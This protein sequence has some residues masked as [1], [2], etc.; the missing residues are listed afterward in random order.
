MRLVPASSLLDR[1]RTLCD[2]GTA[3]DA[4][5]V[6]TRCVQIPAVIMPL[7]ACP[8]CAPSL[9]VRVVEEVA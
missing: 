1:P 3:G 2:L 4:C 8:T 7:N 5:E 9:G 6:F